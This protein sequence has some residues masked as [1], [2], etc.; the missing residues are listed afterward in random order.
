MFLE[1]Y[2][3]IVLLVSSINMTTASECHYLGMQMSIAGWPYLKLQV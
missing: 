3:K 1:E 2:D